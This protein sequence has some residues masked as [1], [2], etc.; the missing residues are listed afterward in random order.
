MKKNLDSIKEAVLVYRGLGMNGDLEYK[1]SYSE[2]ELDLQTRRKKADKMII[3]ALILGDWHS[4]DDLPP[5]EGRDIMFTM[6]TGYGPFVY[7][8]HA[9]YDNGAIYYIDIDRC[10]D[11]PFRN[12]LSERKF[13]W[14]YI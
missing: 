12:Q 5:D 4:I 3:E 9:V 6:V 1:N 8:G 11:G 7:T 2:H 13:R 10:N 14:K